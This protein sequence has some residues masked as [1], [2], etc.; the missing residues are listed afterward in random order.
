MPTQADQVGSCVIGTAQILVGICPHFQDGCNIG[1]GLN[2]VH[3]R[4]T[5]IEPSNRRK[6]RFN[7]GMATFALE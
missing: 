6:W 2:V 7:T 4:W 3:T 5:T 1:Q